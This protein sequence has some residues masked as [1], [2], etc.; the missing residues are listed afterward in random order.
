[1]WAGPDEEVR[2]ECDAV[3]RCYARMGGHGDPVPHARR[4]V[5][6]SEDEEGQKQREHPHA[7]DRKRARDVDADSTAPADPPPVSSELQWLS[8]EFGCVFEVPG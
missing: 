5:N 8:K 3:T 2:A 4:E 7:G 1:M 6:G